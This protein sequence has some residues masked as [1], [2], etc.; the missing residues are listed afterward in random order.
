MAL[1]VTIVTTILAVDGCRRRLLFA[2]V[3]ASHAAVLVDELLGEYALGRFELEELTRLQYA[4]ELVEV[5][6][7]DLAFGSLEL[8]DGAGGVLQF[9]VGGFVGNLRFEFAGRGIEF[10]DV[11][12]HTV[13]ERQEVALLLAGEVEFASEELVLVGAELAEPSLAVGVG[14]CA[15][16]RG[17]HGG[18]QYSHEQ[19]E[20]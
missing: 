10:F 12:F 8:E 16:C 2:A 6:H 3:D 4:A 14:Q 5:G 15:L 18:E 19:G 11:V 13:V 17:W 20:C 1:Y 7:F 9:E